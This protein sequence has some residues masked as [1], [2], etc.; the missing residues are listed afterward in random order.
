MFNKLGSREGLQWSSFLIYSRFWTRIKKKKRE[1]K[2]RPEVARRNDEENSGHAQI[3]I[4][5]ILA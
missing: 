5:L 1:R 4:V 2:A 3:K